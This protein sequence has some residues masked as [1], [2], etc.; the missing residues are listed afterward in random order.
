MS[1][2]PYRHS[3]ATIEK[4]RKARLGKKHS[5]ET[6]EKIRA[7]AIDRAT[8]VAMGLLKPY[9]HTEASKRKMR[10]AAKH[11][12]PS[13]KAVKASVAVRKAR[14]ADRQLAKTLKKFN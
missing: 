11:R 7:A 2:K 6:I 1:K 8:L 3:K 10:E 5:P 13:R 9:R 12:K 14:K 4:I